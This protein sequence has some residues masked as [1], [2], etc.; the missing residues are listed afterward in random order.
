MKS[1]TSGKLDFK[2]K[3][4][5]L[6]AV[7]SLVGLGAFTQVRATWVGSVISQKVVTYWVGSPTQTTSTWKTLTCVH[8]YTVTSSSYRSD[9]G[10]N[11]R[12]IT[13]YTYHTN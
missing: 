3:I 5:L 7:L 2:T 11:P 8:S 12:V 1:L 6:L 10:I 13:N 4:G 9:Y